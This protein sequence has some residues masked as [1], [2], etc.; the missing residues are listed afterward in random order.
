MKMDER[1]YYIYIMANHN[2]T[3]LYV[4]ST[5]D[6]MT[7]VFGHKNKLADGFTKKYNIDKLVYYEVC[8]TRETA[9]AREKQLKGWLKRKK[10]ELVTAFNPLWRDLW[11]ELQ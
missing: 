6:L 11:G 9:V 1:Q 2:D 10:I 3:V 7:R 8:G 5:S 4:G